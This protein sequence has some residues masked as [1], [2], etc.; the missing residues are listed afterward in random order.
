MRVVILCGGKSRRYPGN[1][2]LAKINGYRVLE[3]VYNAAI[4]C[5][6]EV[7]FSVNN[8]DQVELYSSILGISKEKFIIDNQYFRKKSPLNALLTVIRDYSFEDVLFIPGDAAWVTSETLLK[9][10][11]ILREKSDCFSTFIWSN[12]FV[13]NLWIYYNRGLDFD[14]L[15]FIND[16]C[17]IWRATDIFRLSNSSTYIL[18]DKIKI[19]SL[20]LMSINY[21]SDLINPKKYTPKVNTVNNVDCISV[22]F[23]NLWDNPLY[24]ALEFSFKRNLS[25]TIEYLY[26]ELGIYLKLGITQIVRNIADDISFLISRIS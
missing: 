18:V 16:F 19:N 13:V 25:K 22:K 5:F 8:S 1:K 9:A 24:N 7:Y 6:N 23:D 26:N 4:N 12:G 10:S 17:F 11:N 2:L 15:K 14:F 3:S 20:E 21:L